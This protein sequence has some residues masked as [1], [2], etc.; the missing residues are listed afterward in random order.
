MFNFNHSKR[1]RCCLLSM[2][3]LFSP[4]LLADHVHI[5]KAVMM[6]PLPGKSKTSAYFVISNQSNYDVFI[7]EVS[8]TFATVEMHETVQVDGRARMIRNERVSVPANSDLAFER[9]GKHLMLFSVATPL[10]KKLAFEFVLSDGS[11]FQK[12]FTM[13]SW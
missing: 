5:S 4:L 2:A 7:N 6:K 1:L 9:G 3:L 10:P 11:R 8:A 13:K 12:I